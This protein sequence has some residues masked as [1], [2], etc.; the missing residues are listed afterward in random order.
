MI[1]AQH[2]A[3]EGP[4][5]VTLIYDGL[6]T[7]EFGQAYELFGLP[8]PEL[9]A[10]WYRYQSV[11]IEDGPIRA[12]GG[13]EIKAEKQLDVLEEADIILIPGWRGI[14][15]PV[16]ED[17][18]QAL[19]NAHQRGA[20]VA[21][22]CSGA[23]VLAQAGLLNGRT[24]TTHWRY[25]KALKTGFP[26]I[27]VE[28]DRLYSE[29]E[30]VLTSAG[31]AAGIDLALHII[32]QDYGVQVANSVA[33]RLVAP[34]FREGTQRQ[35]VEE[36]VPEQRESRRFAALFE[37]LEKKRAYTMSVCEMAELMGMSQRTFIRKFTKVT[38]QAPAQWRR[39]KQLATAKH[40]LEAED[41]VDMERLSHTCG[42][43]TAASLRHHFRTKY[44]TTP[45]AYRRQFKARQS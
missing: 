22:I 39:A 18:I 19:C 31:S 27:N 15:T 8:R 10:N 7:F 40:L 3:P 1:Q 36:P 2:L 12:A 33:K 9:G 17:L 37:E 28:D 13:L 24:A 26:S 23:F 38:G 14:D 6:C 30:R 43:G 34:P 11:A 35:F 25:A 16:P 29:T 32:R 5:V 21:S 45:T 4:L 44:G 42:F 20:R 41:T